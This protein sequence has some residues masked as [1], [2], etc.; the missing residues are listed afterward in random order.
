MSVPVKYIPRSGDRAEKQVAL[1]K[2]PKKPGLLFLVARATF[3]NLPQ[4]A[5]TPQSHSVRKSSSACAPAVY[6]HGR[7]DIGKIMNGI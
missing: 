1:V 4:A 6:H 5:T 2:P 7:L 3:G